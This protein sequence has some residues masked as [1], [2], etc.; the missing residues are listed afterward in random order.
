M[1]ADIDGNHGIELREASEGQVLDV[2][3]QKTH[4][5]HSHITVTFEDVCFEEFIEKP[6]QKH[7]YHES[8]DQNYQCREPNVFSCYQEMNTSIVHFEFHR[9]LLCCFGEYSTLVT[10]EYG[11][12]EAL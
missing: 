11:L 8:Y 9:N 12:V 3:T 10:E 6:M 2:R 7:H 4:E 1:V 5:Q